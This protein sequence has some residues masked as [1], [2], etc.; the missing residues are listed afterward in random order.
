MNKRIEYWFDYVSPYAYLTTQVIEELAAKYGREIEWKPMLLGVVFKTTNS[1]PLTMRPPIMAK[2]HQHD[3]ERSA[4]VA[5]GPFVVPAPFPRPP[6]T[7]AR[8]CLG[9]KEVAPQ[10]VGEFTRGVTKAYFSGP[11]GLNDIAWLAEFVSGMGLDGAAAAAAC[12]DE[13]Y[14]AQLAAACEEAVSKGVFGA[15]WVIVDGEPFWGNDRLPQL[16][17]WLATGGF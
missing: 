9:M 3:M 13:G 7:T 6:H 10:R 4:R 2:Y 8:V 11:A 16:E 5:G 1:S 12:K 17:K 15:P 14:K